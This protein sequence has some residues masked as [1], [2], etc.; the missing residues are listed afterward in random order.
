MNKKSANVRAIPAVPCALLSDVCDDSRRSRENIASMRAIVDRMV[1][2][3]GALDVQGY[4]EFV[5]CADQARRD[6]ANIEA[7]CTVPES[8]HTAE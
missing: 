5:A 6:L 1:K 2:R 4:A 3:G 8:D 7:G